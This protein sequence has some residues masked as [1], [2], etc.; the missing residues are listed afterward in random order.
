VLMALS[1][2]EPTTDVFQ[3]LFALR[4][5]SCVGLRSMAIR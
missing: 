2:S 1:P 5:Q 3:P 4:V